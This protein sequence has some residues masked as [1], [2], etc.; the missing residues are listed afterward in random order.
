MSNRSILG[1]VNVTSPLWTA[2]LWCLVV[3]SCG[4]EHRLTKISGE[5]MSIAE[6]M[7]AYYHG[8]KN[9]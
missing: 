5:G 2:A 8:E 9:E 6:I 3:T 4:I 1:D 7:A